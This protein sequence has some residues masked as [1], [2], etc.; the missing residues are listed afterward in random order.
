LKGISENFKSN[1]IYLL[2]FLPYLGTGIPAY[3][4][5]L[6]WIFFYVGFKKEKITF[7]APDIFFLSVILIWFVCKLG[8]SS[9]PA[10]LIL[11]RYYFGFF[12]FYYFFRVTRVNIDFSK[13]LFYLGL[14]TIIEAFAVNTVIS[15]SIMPNYPIKNDANA[16]KVYE[17]S[18]MG[19]YQ[20]PYSFGNNSSITATLLMVLL[21][22]LQYLQEKW[23]QRIPPRTKWAAIIAVI[24][25]AS[26]EGYAFLLL[27]IIFLFKP[28][29]DALRGTISMLI[30]TTIYYLIFVVDIGNTEALQKISATYIRFLWDFKVEQVNDVIARLMK[31]SIWIGDKFMDPMDLIVWSDFAW[32]DLFLSA[33]LVGVFVI[34]AICL[35]KICRS[36]MVPIIIFLLG[37][38]HYGA[39]YSLPGQM[40]IGYFLGIRAREKALQAKFNSGAINEG[41]I[42]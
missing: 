42:G 31:S 23:G 41:L 5:C 1:F 32:N 24:L 26:G 21:F 15:P 13:L 6:C 4:V 12:I 35:S 14:V 25:S 33:G 28:Y 40:I 7:Y 29:K 30:L 16:Y 3:I 27:Y 20:R 34:L 36:N 17:T 37:A 11:L 22:Y 10:T 39:M 19:F 38:F 8:Q 2:F 9:L 18:I